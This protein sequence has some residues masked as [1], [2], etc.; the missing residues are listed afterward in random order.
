LYNLLKSV[1]LARPVPIP[2]DDPLKI[3]TGKASDTQENANSTVFQQFALHQVKKSDSRT[4]LKPSAR[5]AT[6]FPFPTVCIRIILRQ[7]I[8]KNFRVNFRMPTVTDPCN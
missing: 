2:I 5:G 7:T 8:V 1:P 6:S 4:T 3:S